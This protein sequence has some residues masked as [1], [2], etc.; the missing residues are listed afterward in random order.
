VKG[1]PD[2]KKVKYPK[3]P[4]AKRKVEA[5]VKELKDAG[6]NPLKAMVVV[7]SESSSG[8]WMVDKCPCLTASRGQAGGGWILTKGRH[9]T[10]PEL[11]AI[12]GMDFGKVNVPS[13]MSNR[14]VGFMIG[15][16]FTQTVFER[17]FAQVLLQ[18]ELVDA[19]PSRFV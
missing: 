10:L 5:V 7:N 3:A 8:N 6:V 9:F 19:V 11:F 1:T 15:N 4:H 17:I 18:S 13:G 12:Q 2:A 14:K 16:S